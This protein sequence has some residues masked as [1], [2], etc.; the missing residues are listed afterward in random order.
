MNITEEVDSK[1]RKSYRQYKRNKKH[2]QGITPLLNILDSILGVNQYTA[3]EETNQ[4][5]MHQLD[6]YVI[7]YK[8][9]IAFFPK[10]EV[11]DLKNTLLI[12]FG[13]TF[14]DAETILPPY[15]QL[16]F[17]SST[18][19]S[20]ENEPDLIKK[21]EIMD[22][23][24]SHVFDL[25]GLSCLAMELYP[26]FRALNSCS[27]Q[28]R[29]TVECYAMGHYRSAISTLLPCIEN[30]I[31]ELGKRLNID[32][33]EN[34]GTNFL[35]N[36]IDESVKKY[37][38]DL[39]YR[40]Y[41]WVPLEAKTKDFFMQ[42]DQRVQIIMNCKMYIKNHLY[43]NSTNYNGT[44]QLNRHSVLHGFMTNYHQ[45][46]NY[47]RLINLLN[48]ICFMLTFSGESVSLFFPTS[49]EKSEKF[50]RILHIYNAVGIFRAKVLDD[51]E[52]ER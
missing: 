15:I 41:N 24:L 23:A 33:P 51:L 9:I 52:I 4:S 14:N 47:L 22:N 39:V 42:F 16:G 21:I 29:E 1:F 35:L 40:N 19:K 6:G 18:S 36:I 34:V 7:N 11:F 26:K 45:R 44:S 46:G 20:I 43:K 30:S 27:V 49:T 32:E 5:A 28:I 31:R 2:N 8:N 50:T 38:H 17:L 10:P 3:S 48:G 13:K 37:I 25:E 12:K